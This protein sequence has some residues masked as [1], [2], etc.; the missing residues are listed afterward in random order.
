MRVF[1]IC[2]IVYFM[3]GTP[4]ISKGN[5]LTC[6]TLH[7]A[8]ILTTLHHS[9]GMSEGSRHLLC[10]FIWYRTHGFCDMVLKGKLFTIMTLMPTIRYSRSTSWNSLYRLNRLFSVVYFGRFL[11][12]AQFFYLVTDAIWVSKNFS[13]WSL[14]KLFS[15]FENLCI[16]SNHRKL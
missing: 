7:F 9:S 8:I 3:C 12:F 11:S 15:S 5:K 13:Y 14:F 16:F 6:Q 1:D 4:S 2:F 10:Q